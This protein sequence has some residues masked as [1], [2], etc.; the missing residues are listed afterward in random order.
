MTKRNSQWSRL[1]L[2]TEEILSRFV[3]GALSFEQTEA[4]LEAIRDGKHEPPPRTLRMVE[5]KVYAGVRCTICHKYF[6]SPAYK[7][8]TNGH[9]LGVLYYVKEPVTSS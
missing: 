4:A 5:C 2:L 6:V 7:V 9:K 8:C 3:I 1:R